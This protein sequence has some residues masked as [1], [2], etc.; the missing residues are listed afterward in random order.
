MNTL[1]K[2]LLAITALVATTASA[3]DLTLTPDGI[4]LR[5]SDALGVTLKY[6]SLDNA[7]R[8]KLEILSD[9]TARLTFST[10]AI[11]NLSIS[12]TGAI[13]LNTA[14]LSG[15]ESGISHSINFPTQPAAGKFQFSTD[16]PTRRP[17]PAERASDGFVFRGDNKRFELADG[18]RGFVIA[19]PY[20]Y[21]EFK[22]FR[23]WNNNPT[24][25]WKSHSHFPRNEAYT[26][27]LAASD[28][29]PIKI[30]KAKIDLASLDRYIPYPAANDEAA[31]PGRGV[32][33]T[34]GWQDGIRQNYFNNRKRDENAIVAIGD[35]LTENFRDLQKHFP[36]L[37]IANRGV[38]GDTSRGI[39]FR[40]PIEVITL[41]PQIIMICAGNNDL[42][43]HGNPADTLANIREMLGLVNEYDRRTPVIFARFPCPRSPTR[44]SPPVPANASTKASASSPPNTTTSPSSTSRPFSKIPTPRKTSTATPP[45]ASTSAPRVT[46]HGPPPS[47]P[48][49]QTNP[50]ETPRKTR[51]K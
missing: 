49:S 13:T 12:P 30:Q 29:S 20:G 48:C 44:P 32:I 35:S 38:G 15:A 21:Q 11:M 7:Q 26:Y 42:T 36:N 23:I 2:T 4:A 5:A 8:T 37:K 17:V 25:E 18:A 10:G 47:S 9:T 28:G 19:L 51:P 40:F 33:R 14:N 1:R 16:D 31:W 22:D 3:L 6:P 50:A 43:A 34:F 45:T 41:N 39:L 27:T 24:F 46:T